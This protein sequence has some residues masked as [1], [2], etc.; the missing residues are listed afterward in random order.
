[1][2]KRTFLVLVF[3][4]TIFGINTVTTSA[5]NKPGGFERGR[6]ERQIR[7][8]ILTLPY[9]NV[10]DAIGYQLDGDTVT[11]T[12]FAVRPTTKKDAE[13]S[14]SDISGVGKVVNNIEVLPLSPSDDRLRYRILQTLVNRGG[15]LYRYFMGSNGSIRII[16]KNGRV[17]LE[18]SADT[19]GDANTAYILTRGVSGSFGVTN[20]LKVLPDIR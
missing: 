20:N 12:G 17:S 4:L 6:I 7:K 14:V 10:F 15:G 13:E 8:E 1:M 3:T 11:L 18:G 9:Y 2:F 19:K 5:Q 16:V